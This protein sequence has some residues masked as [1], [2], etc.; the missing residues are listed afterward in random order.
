[1]AWLEPYLKI[2]GS[3]QLEPCKFLLVN[4][5]NNRQP[6]HPEGKKLVIKSLLAYAEVALFVNLLQKKKSENG[7]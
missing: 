1:M 5:P 2:I 6:C 3:K 7:S 4:T